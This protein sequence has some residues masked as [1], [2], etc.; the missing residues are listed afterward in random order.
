MGK[1]T[2]KALCEHVWVKACVEAGVG[3]RNLGLF[4]TCSWEAFFGKRKGKLIINF[5]IS[6][7]VALAVKAS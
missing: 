2:L 7:V 6:F 3:N 1:N 5:D 4:Q